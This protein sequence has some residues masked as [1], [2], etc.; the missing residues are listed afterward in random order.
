MKAELNL[1]VDDKSIEPPVAAISPRP[2]AIGSWR[3][4]GFQACAFRRC[5]GHTP[6]LP[7]ESMPL[8]SIASLIISWNR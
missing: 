7:G 6:L 2:L 4:R 1:C 5:L 3:F 8:G